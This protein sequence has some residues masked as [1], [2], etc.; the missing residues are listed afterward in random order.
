MLWV[1]EVAWVQEGRWAREVLWFLEAAWA[2]E[3]L[4]PEVPWCLADPAQAPQLGIQACNKF[5]PQGL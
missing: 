4:G 3:C 5:P 1:L 2:R